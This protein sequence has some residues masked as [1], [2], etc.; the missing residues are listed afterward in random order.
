MSQ[1]VGGWG[2]GWARLLSGRSVAWESFLRAEEMQKSVVHMR[3]GPLV[4]LPASRSRTLL[5]KLRQMPF[6]G[7]NSGPA[8][9]HQRQ[10]AAAKPHA[11]APFKGPWD[12]APV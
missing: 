8:N 9:T 6:N 10:P 7:T 2:G 12:Q 5:G 4:E 3:L 1:G 11:R